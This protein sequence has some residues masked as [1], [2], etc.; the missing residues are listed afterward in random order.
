MSKIIRWNEKSPKPSPS[1]RDKRFSFFR[2]GREKKMTWHCITHLNP[3]RVSSDNSTVCV[4]AYL[5]VV[6]EWTNSEMDGKAIISNFLNT[7]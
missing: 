1:P 6:K 4:N 5:G 3:N 7:F 2:S